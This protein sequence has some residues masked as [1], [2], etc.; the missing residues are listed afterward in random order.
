MKTTERDRVLQFDAGLYEF[1][2]DDIFNNNSSNSINFSRSGRRSKTSKSNQNSFST[3]Q[4]QIKSKKKHDEGP[5]SWPKKSKNLS[6]FLGCG[7]ID[8]RCL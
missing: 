4:H 7:Y 2:E 3:P 5:H 1:G 6:I 8:S